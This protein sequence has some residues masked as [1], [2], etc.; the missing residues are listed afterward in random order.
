[1]TGSPFP[2]D[3]HLPERLAIGVAIFVHMTTDLVRLKHRVEDLEDEV[4][5]LKAGAAE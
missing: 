3:P 5:R 4:A 1:M 2:F